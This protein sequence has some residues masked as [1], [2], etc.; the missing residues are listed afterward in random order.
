LV[1][2]DIGRPVGT[3]SYERRLSRIRASTRIYPYHAI[4]YHHTHRAQRAGTRRDSPRPHSIRQGRGGARSLA[5]LKNARNLA[6]RQARLGAAR[7]G[8]ARLG[9]GLDSRLAAARKSKRCCGK[10]SVRTLAAAAAAAAV[11]CRKIETRRL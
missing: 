7:R 11:A 8:A 6:I 2:T 10:I 1:G 9:V 4:L 3:A 5:S